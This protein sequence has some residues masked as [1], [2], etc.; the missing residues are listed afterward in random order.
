MVFNSCK[1]ATI[2]WLISLCC[3][4]DTRYE[5]KNKTKIIA[6]SLS[7]HGM[8]IFSFFIFN[9][10]DCCWKSTV[11][12]GINYTSESCC[13]RGRLIC[14]AWW[15][16]DGDD[17]GRW[18][19]YSFVLSFSFRIEVCNLAWFLKFSGCTK[20]VSSYKQMRC[21]NMFG[22]QLAWGFRTVPLKSLYIF[23]QYAS[24]WSIWHVVWRR[25]NYE[26]QHWN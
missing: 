12:I 5:M 7:A 23:I 15:R 11:L 16:D 20:T 13:S 25:L 21:W 6:T 3:T 18:R 19:Y 9:W 26:S 17:N 10:N 4:L 2:T 24:F 1:I 14:C 8:K 22:F